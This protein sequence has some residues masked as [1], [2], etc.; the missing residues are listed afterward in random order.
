[1]NYIPVKNN[2]NGTRNVIG[3]PKQ[4]VRILGKTNGNYKRLGASNSQ[5]K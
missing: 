4:N 5:P 2:S 1:M 3:T